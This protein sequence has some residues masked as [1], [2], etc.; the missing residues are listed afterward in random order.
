MTGSV[1]TITVT[2]VEPRPPFRPTQSS[3][4]KNTIENR[5]Y[6]FVYK[7][8]HDHESNMLFPL[9][10]RT[11]S[12]AVYPFANQPKQTGLRNRF[13]GFKVRPSALYPPWPFCFYTVSAFTK[14]PLMRIAAA[15]RFISGCPVCRN[16]TMHNSFSD[17][18]ASDRRCLAL[19]P[20]DRLPWKLHLR[21]P[22]VMF[23][24]KVII[25]VIMR[26][27]VGPSAPVLH[28]S[29]AVPR[30]GSSFCRSSEFRPRASWKF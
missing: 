22:A 26:Q 17:F 12:N 16:I 28:G 29:R 3:I 9:C 5:L 7:H 10:C 2:V 25:T 6:S 19:T 24:V 14:A 15:N 8:D 1:R 21:V 27:G 30:G 23:R 18:F 4:S 20:V 11:P 13:N